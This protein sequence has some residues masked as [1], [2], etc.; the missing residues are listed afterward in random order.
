M[1]AFHDQCGARVVDL[2]FQPPCVSH[3][4]VMHEIELFGHMSYESWQLSQSSGCDCYFF[5]EERRCT[6]LHLIGSWVRWGS[7]G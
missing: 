4:E 5:K 6:D 7:P 2:F 3:K 1:K